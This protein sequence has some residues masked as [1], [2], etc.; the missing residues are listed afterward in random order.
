MVS[1]RYCQPTAACRRTVTGLA[2]VGKPDIVKIGPEKRS[3][4]NCI[5][6][7][8]QLSTRWPESGSQ[9]T[10]ASPLSVRSGMS[11]CR[12]SELGLSRSR[13]KRAAFICP[14]YWGS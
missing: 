10:A 13:E 6:A 12:H 9:V 4:F 7:S 11:N 14:L 5:S 8:A 1:K 2:C 3:A